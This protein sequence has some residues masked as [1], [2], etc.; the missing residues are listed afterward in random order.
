M[1]LTHL[2]DG[3]CVVLLR[4]RP[5]PVALHGMS[6]HILQNITAYLE[7]LTQAHSLCHFPFQ[8][9]NSVALLCRARRNV[10][11]EVVAVGLQRAPS[12]LKRDTWS[13]RGGR[14]HDIQGVSNASRS[15]RPKTQNRRQCEWRSKTATVAPLGL[16]STHAELSCQSESLQ[17]GLC[18]SAH[19]S[20]HNRLLL[21]TA[22]KNCTVSELCVQRD[23]H[24]HRNS[25]VVFHCSCHTRT[26]CA[27]NSRQTPL[28]LE[29]TS[30][31]K[32]KRRNLNV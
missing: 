32:E 4:R 26:F 20:S 25:Q 12:A 1:S 13:L 17:C 30:K 18:L 5:P 7:P 2:K 24:I 31:Q 23:S 27:G 10:I 3:R 19:T 6:K 22:T 15:A 28:I 16:L 29:W 8:S 14:A 11:C 9:S 21:L